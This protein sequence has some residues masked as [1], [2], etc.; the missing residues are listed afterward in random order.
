M[1]NSGTIT[2]CR[3]DELVEKVAQIKPAAV[4]SIEHPGVTPGEKGHAPRLT[5]GTPQLVLTFW[6]TEIK[7][8]PQ[9]PDLEQVERGLAFIMEHVTKGSD[10]IIHCHAGKSRSV[11]IALGVLSALHPHEDE[12]ALIKKLLAIRPEAAP[13]I[14]IVEMIDKLTGRN[15]KL[16]KAVNDNAR[17]TAARKQADIGRAKWREENPEKISPFWRPKP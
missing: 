16:L 4:L 14:I 5:N 2:I 12:T 8:V 10:V 6:D 3:A 9:G 11:A 7:Q 17:L 15:G 13:N 1:N